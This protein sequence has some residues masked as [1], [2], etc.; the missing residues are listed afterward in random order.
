MDARLLNFKEFLYTHEIKKKRMPMLLESEIIKP[1]Y[2]NLYNFL[3]DM[4]DAKAAGYYQPLIYPR[5]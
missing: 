3:Q 2:Y 5:G 1:V 4:H